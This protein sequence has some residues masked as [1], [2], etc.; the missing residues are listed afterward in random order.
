MTTDQYTRR[1]DYS[2]EIKMICI[3]HTDFLMLPFQDKLHYFSFLIFLFFCAFC[4]LYVHFNVPETKNL[5]AL[6]I[7]A[8]FQRMHCKS[9]ESQ[10]EKCNEKKAKGDKIVESKL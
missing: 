10:E 7:A 8:E 6:E 5:T 2:G 3:T 1:R 4:A 9:G